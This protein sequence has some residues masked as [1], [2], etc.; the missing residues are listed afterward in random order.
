MVD[1]APMSQRGPSGRIP[2]ATLETRCGEPYI[3]A[4][5]KAVMQVVYARLDKRLTLWYHCHYG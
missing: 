4:V 1:S 2:G 3:K 5:Q